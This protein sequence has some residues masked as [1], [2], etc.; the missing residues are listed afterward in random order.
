MATDPTNP[1][2][3]T[4]TDASIE[5][6][7]STARSSFSEKVDVHALRDLRA[8]A[9]KPASDGKAG[10]QPTDLLS[11]DRASLQQYVES[12]GEKPYRARQLMQWIYGRGITDFDA[13]TDL[14][15][16]SR[17]RF[18]ENATI[19]L[20]K[21]EF[22][23]TA[24][25]GT[26]KWLFTLADGNSIETVFIPEG[27]RGTLCVSSQVG[28]ALDC[29]FCATARQGFNRNLTTGEI[30]SQIWLANA[31]LLTDR[32]AIDSDMSKRQEKPEQRRSPV[33]NVVMMGMGEP[34]LNLTALVPALELMMDDLCFGLSKRKVTVSTSWLCHC[35]L[36]T[37]SCAT[38]WCL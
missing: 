7:V 37:T 28:C 35:M 10:E 11:L 4:D 8:T 19:T 16:A 20:P 17:Q 18:T 30:I 33:T 12:L 23:S 9:V 24:S 27:E 31:L 36:P 3:V 32:Q 15:R 21:I 25:D 14:S 38:S 29:S 2:A 5:A 26:R 13:M 1:T 22:D 6:S 34:L